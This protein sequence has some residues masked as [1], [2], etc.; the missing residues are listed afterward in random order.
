MKITFSAPTISCLTSY[1]IHG[2]IPSGPGD[3]LISILSNLFNISS[4]FVTR[5]SI[6]MTIEAFSRGVK[7]VFSS[8]TKTVEKI[9]LRISV[10]VVSLLVFSSFPKLFMKF[11]LPILFLF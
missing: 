11:R 2:C 10:L 4:S 6:G 1:K 9:E 7:L 5:F 3:L 8:L